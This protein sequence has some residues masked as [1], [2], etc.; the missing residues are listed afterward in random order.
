MTRNAHRPFGAQSETQAASALDLERLKENGSP[1]WRFALSFYG[2]PHVPAACL[3][4]QYRHGVDVNVLLFLLWAGHKG[5]AIE[6]SD[7]AAVL[8]HVGGV[9]R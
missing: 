5:R 6:P 4:L 7:V 8:V 2:R 1:F 3:T 9:A